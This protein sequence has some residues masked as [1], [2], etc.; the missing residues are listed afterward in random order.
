MAKLGLSTQ[1]S[2]FQRERYSAAEKIGGRCFLGHTPVEIPGHIPEGASQRVV[3]DNPPSDLIAHQDQMAVRMIQ[4]SEK[5]LDPHPD[6][7]FLVLEA[8]VEIPEPHRE[9][10][11]DNHFSA[12]RQSG[13]HTGEL[14]GLLDGVKLIAPLFPMPGDPVFHFLI[15]GNGCSDE[16]AL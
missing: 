5:G 13:E 2:S 7:F 4:M 1:G 9:A 16:S 14:K 10:I 6:L 12:F 3:R 8:M 15:Q 11:D